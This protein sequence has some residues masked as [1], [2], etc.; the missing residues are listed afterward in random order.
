MPDIS[1]GTNEQEINKK[2]ILIK[3]GLLKNIEEQVINHTLNQ[4]NG[5]R[6]HASKILGIS[7][8]TLKNKLN[9]YKEKNDII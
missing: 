4:T 5:N 8:K 3:A 2:N 7:I 6:T 1:I 9:K